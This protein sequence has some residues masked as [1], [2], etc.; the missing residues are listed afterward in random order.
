MSAGRSGFGGFDYDPS[1]PRQEDAIAERPDRAATY[2]ET[3]SVNRNEVPHVQFAAA[4]VA[5]W[6]QFILPEDRAILDHVASRAGADAFSWTVLATIRRR[7]EDHVRRGGGWTRQAKNE[8]TA[9]DLLRHGRELL[10]RVP[11]VAQ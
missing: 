8:L 9:G 2:A 3:V 5:R 4:L 1:Q 6:A 10:H 11:K 7:V